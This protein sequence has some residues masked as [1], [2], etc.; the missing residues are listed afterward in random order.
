MTARRLPSLSGAELIDL[1]ADEGTFRSWDERILP[2]DRSQQYAAD[3]A[4]AR[5]RSGTDESVLTGE[6]LVGG[7]RVAVVVSEFSF[8]GGSIGVDAANRL[9]TAIERATRERIPLLAGPASGGTRMQEGTPAFVAMVGIAAAIAA[10]KREGLA[11]LVYLRHPTTG[12][13]MASWGSLGHVTVAEPGAL[14]GFLGPRVYEALY[15]EP[16]PE[17]VQTAENLH[18][19]GVIDGVVPPERLPRLIARILTTIAPAPAVESAGAARPERLPFEQYAGPPISAALSIERTRARARP[20][21][22]SVLRHAASDVVHLSGTGQGESSDGLLLALARFGANPCV[23]VGQDRYAQ[24]SG[25]PWGPAA[26][27]QAQRGQ[28]LSAELGLPLVTLI[29]T[30]GAALSKEAEE[31]GLAGEIARSL[32]SLVTHEQP[33]IAV[34]LGEGTGGGALALLPSDVTIAAQHAWLA[35]LPPEGAS[36]IMHGDTSHAAEMAE[37]QRI[38]AVRL[39]EAGIV[40]WIVPEHPDAASEPAHFSRRVGA[41]IEQ[42]LP[43]I[44][45]LTVGER[46]RR[47]RDRYRSIVNPSVHPLDD[48]LALEARG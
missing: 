6:C 33:T 14:L 10:H 9:V 43:A 4:R 36:A 30:P 1:V 37:S 35:P 48:A 21:V 13:V 42:L 28:R 47:R 24:R 3:L 32:E 7:T 40:D 8:L 38:G 19:H 45:D 34:L 31:G 5:A 20:G 17:G 16:F 25:S 23:V 22:R 18:R 39:R 29:D 12:G 11:Y 27:R 26:L 44:L 15:G 46:L 2:R 41:T